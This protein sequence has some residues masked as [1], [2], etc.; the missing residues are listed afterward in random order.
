MKIKELKNHFSELNEELVLEYKENDNN[1]MSYFDKL[2]GFRKAI[3]KLEKTGL[4]I[5]EKQ[6]W[7]TY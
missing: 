5:D 4:L 2:A 7:I 3:N 6:N 1:G